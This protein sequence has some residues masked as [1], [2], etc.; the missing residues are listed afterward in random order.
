MSVEDTHSDAG[1]AGEPIA[2]VGMSCRLPGAQGP[3]A[4]WQLLDS[5]RSAI[6]SEVPPGRRGT[7]VGPG[8]FLEH[9]DRF[10]PEF[11]GIAPREAAAMDPQQRLMLELSWEAL[12]DAGTPPG[13][14]HGTDTGV[15]VGAISGDYA[16][17]LDRQGPGAITSHTVTGLNRGVIANRVSYTLGLRGPS[18][19]VDTAQSSS[20]V[21]VH[22]ACESLRRGESRTALAGG[23][24]LNLL[25]E[26]TA[27]AVA[28][29]GLSSDGRCFTFDARANGY[30]R[31]E[32]GAVVVLKPLAR[33]LA[34][35]DRV[36]CVI[37]G[38]ATGN[39]GATASLTVPGADAQ[40]DVIAR[41]WQRAGVSPDEAQYVE[42]HGT[43]TRR[44]DP[45]EAA[46]LGSAL[47]TAPGRRTPL[48][49]GSAK[50]NVGHLEGAAGVVGLLK[51]AL[52]IGRRR[53]PASLNFE[54][55]H[56]D[57]PLEELNLR[58]QT[59]SGP[60]PL[61]DRPL[62][63]GVSSF[64]MGGTNC[65][66]V[67]AEAPR[68]E[69][70]SPPPP[71][72]AV[73]W[74]LSARTGPALR[75]QAARLLD[76][77][78]GEP[79]G[80]GPLTD[81]AD[82][83]HSLAVTRTAFEHRAAVTGADRDA[84]LR[85][86]ASLAEREGSPG[87][88]PGGV[89][90]GIARAGATAFLFSGQGAQR[91]GMGRGL[92]AAFPVF[93]DALEEICGHF[94]PDLR[95]VMFTGAE[96]LDQ[97]AYTQTALFAFE[98]ALHRL[99]TACGVRPARLLGH[100]VG[101]IAAAH[102]SGVLSLA[103]ACAL[104]RA[105][106]TLMQAARADGAMV[107]LQ[108]SEEEV[109]ALLNDRVSLAAVNGARSTVVSGDEDEVLR[110]ADRFAGE[111]RRT[112]RLRVSHAFHSPHMD[113]VLADFRHVAEQLT[114]RAATIPVIS[115]LTGRPA[116]E[117][118]GSADYW[119]RH[120]RE[121][122]RFHD[123]LAALRAA[124]VTSYVE[125]G[126]DAVLSALTRAALGPGEPTPVPLLRRDRP[127]A[128]TFVAALAQAHVQGVGV[129]WEAVLPGRRVPLPPY[130]FQR[131]P[132][133]LGSAD[134]ARE[135]ASGGAGV[136]E[137]PGEAS[138]EAPA[139]AL[140]EGGP[141]GERPRSALE[142]V[143]VHTAIVLG[144][145]TPHSVD[146]GRAFKDLG[147]DSMMAV[148]LSDRLTEAT[149]VRLP[150]TL[151]FDHPS[152]ADLA[153]F[154]DDGRRGESSVVPARAERPADDE[155]IAI[156]GMGCRYPGGA[157]TPERL[158]ELVAAGRDAIGEFPDDRGWDLTGLYDPDPDKA[159]TSYTRHGGFLYDAAGFDAAFFGLS[160]R[161][162]TAMDPQQRLLLETSWEALERAGVR[163]ETLRGT[164]TGVF[165][166]ATAQEYGPRLHE[167]ADGH[168]GYL[169]TGNTP[170]VASGR[171]AY[172]L[173]LEG[174][175]V[176]VDTACSS[177]LVALHLAVQALRGGECELA[178][179]GG[180]TVMATPGMFVEFA[181]QRG[182][183]ADGRCK[184]FG[185][186][187]D[188]TGWA[189]G[190][191]MLLLERLSDAQRNGHKILAVIR[192][193]AINQ[194]GASN[195]LTAPNGPSQERVIR[196]ALAT[197]GLTPTDIDAV[198]AHGTGTTL[199]DPIEAQALLAT[200]GQNRD[201]ERP[202]WL[203]SLKSN[204]GHAQ[205]AA[206]VGGIIKMVMAM[207]HGILPKTLHADEP[208]PR[209]D[210]DAGAVAL[211]TEPIPWP[212]TGRPHRA[213]VSSFGISG[214]N[215]HVVLEQAPE[216]QD[217]TTAPEGDGVPG[218]WLL[219]GHTEE[220]LRAQATQLH[221][222]INANPQHSVHD[223]GFTLM[224]TR[225]RLTHT[226]AVIA[227]DREGFLTGLTALANKTPS[228]H[229][230]HAPPTT[231]TTPR[232]AFLFTGQGSQHPGMGRELHTTFPAFADA[233]DT[234]CE[235]LD[236]HLPQPL[237]T[238]VFADD[239]TPQAALLHQTQYTQPAL[240][241]LEVALYRL[242]EHHGVTPDLL[243]GHSVGEIAAAHTAGVLNLTDACTLVTAR[244]RLMQS[245]P[246]GGTMTAIQ[247]T[248]N[249]IRT[250]L[251]PYTG[252]LDLAA[253]NG[254]TS[255]V[256]T[257]DTR[258]ANQLAQIWRERGRKTTNLTVSHAFHSPHMDGILNDFHHIATTLTYTPPH[259]PLISN[260]TGHIATTEELTNPD[261]WTRQLRHTVR[262]HDGIQTLHHNN[263]TT[264]LEL[265]P[266]PIL[267]SL[268]HN[269]G[270]EEEEGQA[271]NATPLLRPGHP[272]PHTYTTALTQL[273]L[274][275]T[276]LNPQHLFP[277][278][279]HTTLPTYPFQRHN[280]WLTSPS[281]RG[282]VA[283]LGL[284]AAGHPLLGAA[285]DVAGNDTAVLTGQISLADHAWLGDHVVAGS[286]LLPGAAFVEL[287]LHAGERLGCGHLGELTLEAP[288][289][290]PERG[291][292]QVQVMV[293]APGADGH[294]PVS[295][296]ARRGD[297]EDWT[298]HATGHLTPV[299]DGGDDGS[300][301]VVTA[302]PP[303]GAVPFDVAGLYERLLT[304]GY[305]YGPS[306][307]G[308]RAAWRHG[309]D[310]YAEIRLAPDQEAQAPRYGLH[311]AALDAA[312]HLAV[313]DDDRADDDSADDGT[314]VR[315][316][317]LPFV[318]SGVTCRTTGA[319]ALRVRVRPTGDDTV[320]LEI[321]DLAGAP[322]ASAQALT[323]RPAAPA[324]PAARRDSWFTV[325]WVPVP[326]G[327]S[328]D[329]AA[330]ASEAVVHRVTGDEPHANARETLGVLQE[331]LA[332]EAGNGHGTR[333]RREGGRLAVVTSGAV[334]AL[335]GEGVPGLAAA[336]VWGLV[337]SAQS[338]HPGQFTLVDTDDPAPEMIARALRT[339]E[340]QVAV[341]RGT[342]LVPRLVRAAD[343]PS[344]A[345]PALEGTVLIT[346][347]TGTLGSL[348]ARHLVTRHGARHLLL[349]SRTGRD[350]ALEAELTALGAEVTI[351]AC[352]VADRD[353]LAGL[354]GSLGRPLT[355]VIHAAG[356]LDDATIAALT[357][358]R[359]R[360]VLRPK[361][362]AALALHE[363]T[364]ELDL[365]AFVLFSSATGL[366][367]SPGQGNYTAAGT[368]LDALAAHRRSAGLPATSLAWGLW[369]EAS[370]MS[371]HLSARDLDRMG[372]GG[373]LPLETAAAL[374]LL[375]TALAGDLPL[376]VPAR[377][378]LAAR[379]QDGA[380]PPLLR[381]LVRAPRQR[382]AVAGSGEP[383]AGRLAALPAGERAEFAL[384]LV[385]AEIGGALGHASPDAVE[386][387]RAFKDLGF[388]SL[389]SVEL[390][391]RLN[392]ATGL[393][394]SATVVF[395]HP[396]PDALAA[397][398]I[399]EALGDARRAAPV[400]VTA[401][402]A[403]PIA[404][405][406][407]A[408]RYPGGVASPEELWRLVAEGTDAVGDF[409]DDRG[410]DLDGLFDPDPDHP[411]TSYAR[412]GGFLYDAAEFDPAFFGI[413]P[414]EAA[415]VDPQQRLLL[416]T[417]WE[418]V[419]RA[420]IDPLS[421]H[422]SD[423]GVFAGIMYGDYG[424]RLGRAPEGV[425]GYLGNGSR[426]SVASGRIA[427]TLGL[428]GPAVTVDTACSSSLV[429][430]HLAAQALRNGEC[431]LAFAGGA[432]VMATPSTFVE[433]SRQRALSPDGRCKAFGASADGTGWAEGTGMLLLE[434]LSDARRNGHTVL[435]V[436]RGTAVNQ[437]GASN[438]LTAPNGP[439]QE[440]VI[441]Q[442][443]AT[444]GL[445]PTD[446]DAVEAHG[447]GTTLGD[448]IE[449]Q[450]LLATYGQNRDSERPLWLG[451]LKSNIGHAQAAAGVGG[452]IKMVMAMHHGILP[453]TLHADEPT[454]H[455]DWGQGTVRLLT[456]EQPWGTG[457]D[458][459]RRAGVSSFGISGTNAHVIIE[460]P[461]G[462]GTPGGAPEPERPR[463]E[464]T[465]VA[466]FVSG[467]DE[468]GLRAQ[469]GRLHAHLAGHPGLCLTDVG[470]SLAT[471]RA[472]LP[473][474]AAVV[475]TGRAEALHGLEALAR[476]ETTPQTVRATSAVAPGR[477]AF[478]L[479]GQGSQRLAMG[480]ELHARVP[481][482]ARA[483]DEICAH[484]DTRLE[485][486]LRAV[487]FAA[488]DSADAALL[489]RTAYTQPALFAV[490]TA[491]YRLVEGY[492]VLPD[493]LLGHSIGEVTAAH[494][495][496][497]LSLADACTLV[498]AR[499]RLMQAARADGGMA[500]VQATEE[501]VLETLAGYGDAATVAAVNGPRSVVVSG[502]E[503]V[504]DEIAALWRDRGRKTKRLPVSHAF[505]S[506]HMDEALD[507]FRAVAE[508]L[509]FHEPRVAVLSNVT[510]EL[511]TAA[512]LRSPDY[513]TAHIR[514]P[515]RFHDCVRFLESQGVTEYLELGDGVLSAMV[516]ECVTD[517]P[518]TLVPLLR[519]GRPEPGTVTAALALLGLHGHTLD[520]AAAYPGGRRVEL[521][522]Y[523]FRRD[524]YWLTGA[525]AP[526]DAAGLG[527]HAADHPLLGTSVLIAGRDAH[528]FSGRISLRTHPWLADHTVRGS[529]LVPGTGLLE[530]ALYCGEHVGC[531]QVE[532]LTLTA[533]LVIP[534]DGGV[535]L[536]V[537]VAEPD[538]SG[539]R[540]IDVYSRPDTDGP[541][542][543]WAP[544]AGGRLVRAA[545]Q[546]PAPTD[547]KPVPGTTDISPQATGVWPP[548]G[549]V[550]IDLGGAYER[551]AG[552]GLAYGPAF[553]GLS[554]LW[555]A[556]GEVFAE[557]ALDEQ[558]QADA[559]R[560]VLH[561]ALLD[562]ALHPLLPGVADPDVPA[563][564]PFAWSEAQVHAVGATALRVR[565]T[566]TGTDSVSL[567]AT[568]PTG[569][570]VARIGSLTLR[571]L[572]AQD[573]RPGTPEGLYALAWPALGTA[574][575]TPVE[576]VRCAVLGT[577]DDVHGLALGP[578]VTA[579]ADL[580]ALL[581]A[582]VLPDVV[583]V[584]PAGRGATGDV[585]A[586][587]R[588]AAAHALTLV[589][590]WLAE[591]RL[592]ASRL[593][594]L[595]R[596]AVA[597]HATDLVDD[598]THAAVWG[599]VRSAQS[600]HPDRF[601][602]IDTDG[603][604]GSLAALVASAEPQVAWRDGRAHVPRLSRAGHG[605]GTE[606]PAWGRGTVLITG[607]TGA[608][609]GVLARHLVVRHDARHLLL[610]SRRGERAP[611]AEELREQLVELG[612]EVTFAACDTADREALADVVAKIPEDRPLTA[613]VH[614]AGVLDDGVVETMT[615]EQLD[616]VLRPKIDAAWNLHHVT[617]GH[618]L[619]AFVLYSSVAGTLGTT[620]QANYAAGNAFLD[621]LA[622]HRRAH[623]LPAT[624][625]AWGLWTE[626]SALTGHLGTADLERMSR[627]GLVPLSSTDAMALFDAASTSAHPALAL[628][629]LRRHPDAEPPLVLRELLPAGPRRR[630][631]AAGG[632]PAAPDAQPLAERLSGLLP[633]DQERVLADLVRTH[634]AGV[635]GHA[636]TA[637]VTD[638]RAFQD[639]GFDSLIAVEFR[640]RLNAETGRRLPTTVVFDHPTPQALT[641]Y[642]RE[643]LAPD[644]GGSAVT[645]VL[646]ELDRVEAAMRS[647]DAVREGVTDRLRELLK[648]ADAAA[649]ETGPGEDL[650]SATDDELF[651]LVDELE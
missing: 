18:L 505:H 65:H 216:T 199:G 243:L 401:P 567:T 1:L 379:T 639:M 254:P 101:E 164:R 240:F 472:A 99:V 574:A 120:L 87:P 424:S 354:L 627:M 464:D 559:G 510:G 266:A 368:F 72:P 245:A 390:R 52:S 548:E 451:S 439:S 646:A 358:E 221:T 268:T 279:H 456:E 409:P 256:I 10:D 365:S 69:Q 261:Y 178:F 148:E 398:L 260:I 179:A 269:N 417:V 155:P 185:A 433:F 462:S 490:E 367:G 406:G 604:G 81:V 496:G 531:E 29:G 638:D 399:A 635:L 165:V 194:D 284:G 557:V 445:T 595:T 605:D 219:S 76:A 483:L 118:I 12:E 156:V 587:A 293:G 85:G 326:G 511:A 571:P 348:V 212:E 360:S 530:L 460:Q 142:L 616:R 619:A 601:T 363:L 8:G 274:H 493:Y 34:D 75:E 287:A 211:L 629:H 4:Y 343:A 492:G 35:G 303:Q 263:I 637:G 459:P 580:D 512:Q 592:A 297:E 466:L 184:A 230:H 36:H 218:P 519:A 613:V 389:T 535:Q 54:A 37:L 58:V 385:R 556:R 455:V 327:D 335:P 536:Q 281:A 309:D 362:D 465:A 594:L 411:G 591:E 357:P 138:D 502:D 378:N 167:P 265:G 452:I 21:A 55:P 325:E 612:A 425:E 153:R 647:A 177:S 73:P 555:E 501:E 561:P 491:L 38:S 593:V 355:A 313:L 400:T 408:C 393:R 421:L 63:A 525:P 573:A 105:R 500:A 20:L 352:D 166:G 614:A 169:L 89:F 551:V 95:E 467:R 278:A 24:H 188:G 103:D 248:E 552:A 56:P 620:G 590:S 475:A 538:A 28:F 494:I 70:P 83:G 84:L 127:E 586:E 109:T 606:L 524:R 550:E 15:F 545:T 449:A 499:G 239:N 645:S 217:T 280:Y 599:L 583:V 258:A 436:V 497:V 125:I 306:F 509:A 607:A 158:W 121:A 450:A 575:D 541:E 315:P 137:G 187:A 301:S 66:V 79:T 482:F 457:T 560:F 344:R 336:P 371:G 529:V 45:V 282:D 437:D 387:G 252:L 191:G 447:T 463:E 44:G 123:G 504:V 249:E 473:H 154:L 204:I 395:D 440:R 430:L 233:Y 334:A 201:S 337:R 549:A 234:I 150:D 59:A 319:S 181:R 340:P 26:G 611:G 203:G 513:W 19:A 405:V 488:P 428:E 623:G 413:T 98:V 416:E 133:W 569:T 129:D 495:A 17:L 247:A 581:G 126:P 312:L 396:S 94:Q 175:A 443:L 547:G 546:D 42:L 602:L 113:G 372:R 190:T 174:P 225:A 304:Q 128:E 147:F 498:A 27:G 168:E 67:L 140:A 97:T 308:V 330:D 43:G 91:A 198:E 60:W 271:I 332:G 77:V 6:T 341:R 68:A 369:A 3:D 397:H 189:E 162:A 364:R 651:A 46:A 383:W 88:N 131:G 237:K 53:L 149:G 394:L 48:R 418:A 615:G 223:V 288:L 649:E 407:M 518:A 641:A 114:Y 392:A 515:V 146:T 292:V 558:G 157:T 130:A 381:G 331:W 206:G 566:R 345:M 285:V 32:G 610:V 90:T 298:R 224:T 170:S 438:G 119:V 251:A 634:V 39:D 361:A 322:V 172:T 235:H 523:A 384:S 195:G 375:D 294:R 503:A 196:Q 323:L 262:F 404:I 572:A 382:R 582:E 636:D 93:A 290:L 152:P 299:D 13:R 226:A 470:H 318:W 253:V 241:A 584:P 633:A 480:R 264:C 650:D 386:T 517:E 351:A 454:P 47:G 229:I 186:S 527:L 514:R 22:L 71:P 116:G 31:G 469:A 422:G 250:S 205:A 40:A 366:L 432:T 139:E 628:T 86:L 311:P 209:V 643:Q 61:A 136:P 380:V 328:V 441:R 448:P 302:W 78:R 307:Q 244:G 589:R 41:A 231:P 420:G 507:E 444:A 324:A 14:L 537:V 112:R 160:P 554:R 295:L 376:A 453:K 403:E 132:Y 553:T 564:L 176:T 603:S 106:G 534:E 300:G 617:A 276:P 80:A 122:V 277:H 576:P 506:P 539:G 489:H 215:A 526:G 259:T 461:G 370:G 310:L 25:A 388:D 415:A 442:A 57:I 134:G 359:M 333:E 373:L 200:Y 227:Q 320:T 74:L 570:P 5:G 485:R 107:A 286:V 640:N 329:A 141:T 542:A 632:S 92:A 115:N 104:V 374:D 238:I 349:V 471:T 346:G 484:F 486:P 273:T 9:V 321:T 543:A 272:E 232:T 608:L 202:L 270:T 145:V 317:R 377:L 458:R 600:E 7:A 135:E 50:T 516:Q 532:E 96:R 316:P 108:A 246:T 51:A 356:V 402:S 16:V 478:L 598:L 597:A 62:V 522:T 151:L 414:R 144:H 236:P 171:I 296:H 528:L 391:N 423:T 540:R 435:A 222:F 267:T 468:P 609:G 476:G 117:E 624:S 446:I 289:P 124:G 622:A 520:P 563:R 305:D 544:H 353:A 630:S 143:R 161:E 427:Y 431:R 193:S 521:P 159:G 412:R 631:T 30:V 314:A 533:P 82:V 565:L 207:H 283:A 644:T 213:G 508:R 487:L 192:G 23:V 257:G 255:T 110:I 197:A 208:T 426:G 618:D 173:G 228:P 242:L 648:L 183:S 577:A 111:G 214:T 410:W 291:G 220:A 275:G 568:D 578:S 621:A 11:F 479:P 625:L 102:V 347:G 163:A 588:A 434:R 474:R 477:T 481:E 626:T 64:G 579:Y 49:V 419:E 350:D 429:A 182:L 338:E 100:S 339:G 596:G 180:A 562:A 342:L 33:A 585:A 210:W 2:V 642:L